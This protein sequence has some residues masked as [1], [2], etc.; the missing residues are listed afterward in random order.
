[1]NDAIFSIPAF[2]SSSGVVAAPNFNPTFTRIEE[3]SE[4]KI[5]LKEVASSSQKEKV[6]SPTCRF[7][8]HLL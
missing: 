2:I 3:Y 1:M 5:H 6:P 7:N 4:L 8:F